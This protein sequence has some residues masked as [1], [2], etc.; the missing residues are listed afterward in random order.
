VTDTD[1]TTDDTTTDEALPEPT[2]FAALFMEDLDLMVAAFEAT[3]LA[4]MDQPKDV[5]DDIPVVGLG[6]VLQRIRDHRKTLD[7]CEKVIEALLHP[8]MNKKPLRLPDGRGLEPTWTAEG[9]KWDVEGLA[10]KLAETILA[11]ARDPETGALD[12]PTSVLML[13]MLEPFGASPKPLTTWLK[14]HAPGIRISDYRTRTGGRP[15][16]KPID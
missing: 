10:P 11:E 14:A 5:R 1:T 12:A 3:V 8:R 16:I 7:D 15:K 9:Q 2:T 4:L 13:R 6:E